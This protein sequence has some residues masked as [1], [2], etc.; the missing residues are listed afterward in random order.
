[1]QHKNTADSLVCGVFSLAQLL[2]DARHIRREGRLEHEH[3]LCTRVREGEARGVECMPF[4]FIGI[5]SIEVVAEQRVPQMGE[6]N[7]DLMCAS[8]LKME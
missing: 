1:M 6:V 3:F 5:S 7:T 4:Y 8:C 2:C